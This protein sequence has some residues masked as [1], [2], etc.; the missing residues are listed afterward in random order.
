MHSGVEMHREPTSSTWTVTVSPGRAPGAREVAISGELD[1]TSAAR[2]AEVLAGLDGHALV[3]DLTGLEFIDAAGLSVLLG[4]G[5][6]SGGRL[7][8]V[9]GARGVVRRVIEA[10]GLAS[11]LADAKD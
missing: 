8:S 9:R 11:V 3:I 6:P 2:L 7:L 4:A 1:S 5:R 10:G